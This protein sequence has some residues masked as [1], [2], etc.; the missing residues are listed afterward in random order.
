[1]G[2]GGT[3][4]VPHTKEKTSWNRIS[5]TALS[6]HRQ[7]H[8]RFKIQD[9]RFFSNKLT[10]VGG[11]IANSLVPQLTNTIDPET[12]IKLTVIGKYLQK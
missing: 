6:A 2:I 8:P 5:A 4:L 12:Y 1:M 7:Q 11:S 3:K 9:S 10:V